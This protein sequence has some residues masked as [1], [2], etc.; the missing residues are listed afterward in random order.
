M[1]VTKIACTDDDR[2]KFSFKT[3]Q[4]IIIMENWK[5]ILVLNI[6]TRMQ[7]W[8]ALYSCLLVSSHQ[9]KNDVFRAH[10]IGDCVLL[11]YISLF[12]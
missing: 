5:L 1:T 7:G 10:H 3:K 9:N 4:R 8:L 12:V 11:I 6:W 2:N